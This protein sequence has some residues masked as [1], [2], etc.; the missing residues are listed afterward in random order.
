[1]TEPVTPV[2]QVDADTA[3]PAEYA[4]VSDTVDSA[5]YGDATSDPDGSVTNLAAGQRD[6]AERVEDLTR[7]LAR[8]AASIE[9]LADDAKARAQRERQGADL[10]LVTELFA[11]LGDTTACART[12]ESDREREAFEAI[13][14]RIERLLIGRGGIL[15]DPP[16]DTPFDSLTMEAADVVDTEDPA[17]DRTVASVIQPGLSVPGRSIRPARVV[18]RRHR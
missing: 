3:G 16:T 4:P 7:V 15:V 13:T 14:T 12:A 1:M 9:R 11:L 17:F 2:T 5:E 8:Q 18:V 10:P 6:L